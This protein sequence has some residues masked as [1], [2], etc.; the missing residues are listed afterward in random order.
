L[1]LRNGFPNK[2]NVNASRTVDLPAPLVP[3]IRVVVF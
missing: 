3:I 1:I 2:E